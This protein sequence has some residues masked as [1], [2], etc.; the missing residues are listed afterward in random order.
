MESE[1]EDADENSAAV[2]LG[3]QLYD[4]LQQA[5]TPA[6]LARKA[7]LVLTA[8]LAMTDQDPVGFLQETGDYLREAAAELIEAIT[9]ADPTAH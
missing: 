6:R 3:Q 8:M 2:D 5:G 9:T 7:T 4:I 1:P